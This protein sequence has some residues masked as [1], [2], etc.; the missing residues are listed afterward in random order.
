V[1]PPAPL[2][3]PPPRV[4]WFF[5]LM[6]CDSPRSSRI[7]L[8]E[9]LFVHGRRLCCKSHIALFTEWIFPRAAKPT[10]SCL[11]SNFSVRSPPLVFS[12]GQ[13]TLCFLFDPEVIGERPNAE[14]STPPYANAAAFTNPKGFSCLHVVFVLALRNASCGRLSYSLRMGRSCFCVNRALLSQRR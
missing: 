10:P 6:E 11:R 12:P 8:P 9:R 13:V 14:K 5:L 4:Y 7:F 1:P 2:R 3:R